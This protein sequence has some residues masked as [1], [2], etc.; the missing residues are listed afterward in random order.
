MSDTTNVLDAAPTASSDPSAASAGT[1]GKP[2]RRPAGLAGMVLAELQGVAADLGITGTA[3]M[4][5]GQ[6]IEAI[7]D[8]Q[9]GSAGNRSAP[10]AKAEYAAPAGSGAGATNG[11]SATADGGRAR[12]ERRPRRIAGDQPPSAAPTVERQDSDRQQGERQDSNRQ[13]S[14]RQQ[15]ERQQGE[16]APRDREQPGGQPQA[17]RDQPGRPREDDDEFGSRSRR[18]G[19]YRDRNRSRRGET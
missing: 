14:N 2:R 10:E 4:R 6:L 17:D 13:D 3:R 16:R 18:R 19:R 12:R 9:G 11:S 15:G 8:R 5:K 7:Q 1:A